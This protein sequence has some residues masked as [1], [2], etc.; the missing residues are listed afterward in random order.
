MSSIFNRIFQY[1]QREQRTPRED[2]FTETFV[3][4]IQKYDELRIALAAWLSEVEKIRSVRIET[5]RGFT[6]A[7]SCKLRRPDIWM[8]AKDVQDAR[9][10]IIVENKIDSGEGENQLA[11]Y[12]KILKARPESQSSTL[13]YLT[14]YSSATDSFSDEGVRFKHLR[15]SKVYDF[16]QEHKGVKNHREL[17]I[18]LLRLMEDW[19]MDGKLRTASLRAMVVSL[20]SEVG[21]KLV[22]L[23]NEAWFSSGLANIIDGD[24][25]G[26]KRWVVKHERGEQWISGIPGYG[27]ALWMGFRFDRGDKD[28]DVQD[29]EFPSPFVAVTPDG[30]NR[31]FGERMARPSEHWT[32]P[33]E[34]WINYEWI[35]Q[36]TVGEKPHL[37]EPLDE[38]YK[39]F[40]HEAFVELKQALEG[41][42]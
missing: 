25:L 5:Q 34:D 36:P 12:A 9:H 21:G 3:A 8:E 37:G 22:E 6:V 19:K 40:F 15:W 17:V 29:I 39:N 7:D 20:N 31:K 28:W 33:V 41:I 4:V 24:K 16:L 10:W 23:Q 14:K 30:T 38:Y 42:Q 27:L 2:Y 13:V 1:R 35:R 11:D 26:T 18:E 32:G